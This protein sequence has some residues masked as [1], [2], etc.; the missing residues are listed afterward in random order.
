MVG[1]QFLLLIY[2]SCCTILRTYA[3]T[4]SQRFTNRMDGYRLKSES[5]K[6]CF[7]SGSMLACMSVC[8][9]TF[10]CATISYKSADRTCCLAVHDVTFNGTKDDHLTTESG[11]FTMSKAMYT[12]RFNAL[13]DD[14]FSLAKLKVFSGRLQC[15]SKY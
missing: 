5:A 7:S 3:V 6:K 10:D 14:I 11:W 9:R 4:E 1:V 8:S 2:L 12:G 13:S 15:Y